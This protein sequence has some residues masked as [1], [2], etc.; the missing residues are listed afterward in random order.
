MTASHVPVPAQQWSAFLV[1]T[2]RGAA[3][4]GRVLSVVPFGAFVDLGH[5]VHG[6]LHMSEWH[7]EPAE[8]D[9]LRLRIIEVDAERQRVS[10]TQA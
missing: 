1:D 8:G 2:V 7:G 3:V 9:T 4:E 5:G 10:L 6:L